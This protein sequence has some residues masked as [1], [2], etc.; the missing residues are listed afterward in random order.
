MIP[1][2]ESVEEKAQEVTAQVGYIT[3]GSGDIL[4]ETNQTLVLKKFSDESSVTVLENVGTLTL[5]GLDNAGTHIYFTSED[6]SL[7]SKSLENRSNPKRIDSD[8]S[9]G[10]RNQ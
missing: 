7:Y 1:L 3:I 6:G 4:E 9:T 2:N 8:V 5:A 10:N